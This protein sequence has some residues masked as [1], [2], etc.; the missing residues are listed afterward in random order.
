MFAPL[1]FHNAKFVVGGEVCLPELECG[2]DASI[3][4]ARDMSRVGIFLC[5]HNH[6][7]SLTDSHV[8]KF[9]VLRFAFI[10]LFLYPEV[11]RRQH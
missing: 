4:V 3:N 6:V 9:F 2:K 10:D 7:S 11:D 5:W 8:S 1:G